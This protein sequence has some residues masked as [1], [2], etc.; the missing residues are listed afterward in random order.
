MNKIDI[1]YFIARIEALKLANQKLTKTVNKQGVTIGKL[2]V[3]L[4]GV[5]EVLKPTLAM[6][7]E[8]KV[9]LNK[10]TAERGKWLKKLRRA[11]VKV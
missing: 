1:S 5:N 8:T 6:L 10:M 7:L 4:A 3:E 9:S 2:R 11:G